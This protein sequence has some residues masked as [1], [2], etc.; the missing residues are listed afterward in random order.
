[1]IYLIP[2]LCKKLNFDFVDNLDYHVDNDDD[3]YGEEDEAEQNLSQ[4]NLM[5]VPTNKRLRFCLNTSGASGDGLSLPSTPNSISSGFSP[6]RT[7]SGR[8]YIAGAGSSAEKPPRCQSRSSL[9]DNV[10]LEQD[11]S[12]CSQESLHETEE[13]ESP[14][15]LPTP[16]FN[17]P[18]PKELNLLQRDLNKLDESRPPPLNYSKRPVS[19]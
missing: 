7:R 15:R 9:M 18:R 3:Y 4:E 17:Q 6:C 13:K 1:M 5:E 11:K 8:I 10:Q 12:S 16:T 2:R 14:S 19:R